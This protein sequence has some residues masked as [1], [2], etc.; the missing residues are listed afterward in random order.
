MFD[1]WE[2]DHPRGLL[3]FINSSCLV[4]LY[5]YNKVSQ[6]QANIPKLIIIFLYIGRKLE[7][8]STNILWR[9]IIG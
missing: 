4:G 2:M 8:D 9:Y 7:F 6:L 1:Y 5:I 3:G